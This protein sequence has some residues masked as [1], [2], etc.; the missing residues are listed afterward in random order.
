MWNVLGFNVF[1]RLRGVAVV[2]AVYFVIDQLF[3][4]IIIHVC[5]TA[6]CIS[7]NLN[8]NFF[9]IVVIKLRTRSLGLV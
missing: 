7:I 2:I 3:L 4:V 8:L 1:T 5:C 9:T 6:K